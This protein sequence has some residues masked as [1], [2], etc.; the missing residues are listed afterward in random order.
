[1]FS[2]LLTLPLFHFPFI[3][4]QWRLFPAAW[5]KAAA[6]RR[7]KKNGFHKTLFFQG[8]KLPFFLLRRTQATR[9]GPWASARQGVFISRSRKGRKWVAASQKKKE[10]DND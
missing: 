8:I 7:N 6:A 1:M 2:S 9:C 5:F 3:L 4:T 10:T